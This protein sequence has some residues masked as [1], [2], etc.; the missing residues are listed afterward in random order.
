MEPSVW[1][2]VN[3]L[4]ESINYNKDLK[5]LVRSSLATVRKALL[6]R[7]KQAAKKGKIKKGI[8]AEFAADLLMNTHHGLR[9][10]SR[11]GK[12][13]KDLGELIAFTIE[14]LRKK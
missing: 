8:S 14:T 4:C 1:Y 10:N 7:T 6:E 11:D 9:V 5:K 3:S 13:V 2:L 12:S